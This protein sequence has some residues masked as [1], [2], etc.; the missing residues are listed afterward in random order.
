MT[1]LETLAHQSQQRA[2]KAIVVAKQKLCQPFEQKTRELADCRVQVKSQ[3][4]A[5]EGLVTS[6][7]SRTVK[8]NRAMASERELAQARRLQAGV[9][10]LN[11]QIRI[12][13][14]AERLR[15]ERSTE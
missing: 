5:L 2:E 11:R 6:C 15:A 3:A 8:L 7:E 4:K 13:E 9:E 10:L 12:V 14:E 1:E